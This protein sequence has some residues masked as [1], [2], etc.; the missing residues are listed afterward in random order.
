[1]IWDGLEG[2][3]QLAARDLF[4]QIGELESYARSLRGRIIAARGQAG[5]HGVA[6]D[7]IV[8]SGGTRRD[9]YAGIDAIVDGDIEGEY[10]RVARRLDGLRRLAMAILYGKSGKG[11]LAKERSAD[12]AY[13]LELR[14]LRGVGWA[15]MS[16]DYVEVE[17]TTRPADY[18]RI[19]ARRALRH[20]DRVGAGALVES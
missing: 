14:Y 17:D 15:R 16:R 19:R 1:M 18:L 7:A 2:R 11:G 5:P 12:D 6:T 9:A 20:I 4:E 10:R 8:V 3:Y 13:I